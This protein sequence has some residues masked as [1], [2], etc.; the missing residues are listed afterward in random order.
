MPTA[1]DC[2]M[3]KEVRGTPRKLVID[4]SGA[5]NKETHLNARLGICLFSESAQPPWCF[6][7]SKREHASVWMSWQCFPGI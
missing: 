7:W 1:R 6:P 4:I 2:L 5:D 3:S